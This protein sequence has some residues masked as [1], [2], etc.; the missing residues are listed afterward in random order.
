MGKGS[1]RARSAACAVTASPNEVQVSSVTK[2]MKPRKI[3]SEEFLVELSKKQAVPS[4]PPVEVTSKTGRVIPRKDGGS[5]DNLI[6]VE[7]LEERSP[8]D[9]QVIWHRI[10]KNQPHIIHSVVNEHEYAFFQSRTISYPLFILPIPRNYDYELFVCRFDKNKVNLK[11][12]SFN[13]NRF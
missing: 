8:R 1:T 5:L 11:Q 13:Q 4:Q 2:Y 3:S 9:I 10:N 6:S 7:L 12:L